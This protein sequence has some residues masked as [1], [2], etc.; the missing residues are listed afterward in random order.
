MLNEKVRQGRQ[1]R[2]ERMQ[3]NAK[4]KRERTQQTK[5]VRRPRHRHAVRRGAV[6]ARASRTRVGWR[7]S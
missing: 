4:T 6:R 3:Q 1:N 5:A 2:D 7:E